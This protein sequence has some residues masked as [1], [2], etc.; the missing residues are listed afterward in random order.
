VT[1]VKIQR[2]K[3]VQKMH[4]LKIWK[5]FSVWMVLVL[6]AALGVALVPASPVQA[7]TTWYVDDDNCPGPG[8]GTQADPFCKIQDAVDAASAGDTINV[9]A[10]TYT[11]AVTV[12]PGSDL[13]IQGAGRDVTT[14]ISP[15]DDASRMHCIKC[16]D[17][18]NT[19]LDIS[20]FTF[21]VEDNAISNSGIAIRINRATTGPLYLTIHDNKFVETT[22]ISETANS[23][24][25]CHNRF[26][27]RGAEAPI[28]IYNNLDYTTGGIAMSNSRAF[29]IY[30]NTFDGSSDAIYFGYGCPTGATFGDH[31][32]YG[33]TFLNADDDIV[34][35]G[36][37]PAILF[38]DN[39]TDASNT[40]L[41]SII[42]NNTFENND[43]AICFLNMD[44]SVTYPT[45]IVRYNSFVNNLN[46]GILVT[47]TNPPS[48]NAENNWWGANDGPNASPGSGDKASAN[49]DYSPWLVIGISASPDVVVIGGDT[50]NITADMTKNSAGQNTSAQGHIPDGT[51]II[52]TTTAGSIGSTTATKTTTN[53]MATATLTLSGPSE[54]TVCAEAPH[55]AQVPSAQYAACTIVDLLA[56][57]GT[58]VSPTTSTG[59][60][61]LNPP[62]MSAQYVSVNPQQTYANQPVTITTNV[63]NTGDEAGNLNIALK[64]NG[65]VE[66]TRMVSV[67]PQGTQPVKFTVTKAQP[68]TYTVDIAGQKGSFTVLGAGSSTGSHQNGGLIVLIVM[69][70]LILATAVVLMMTF[71]RPA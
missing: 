26:A 45:D 39:G 69:A 4:K 37:W 22:T 38:V 20:G 46:N 8:T 15:A 62:Q 71:R 24:L 66:Q 49:V 2:R 47:G 29:D 3:G 40:I 25:L 58:G 48:V 61:S 55:G 19:T 36:P 9:A 13:T 68:G 5:C 60:R 50:S 34:P 52:F 35:G 33:N 57:P 28:K 32:I 59:S 42:E 31:H 63:V 70:L 7:Q 17:A 67:G 43:S 65:Q 41:P 21:S 23:M 6:V 14:W 44:G 12:T 51:Q 27:A 1:F 18:N 30:N 11:E 10:G 64:I 16:Q 54:A 56:P 53:G